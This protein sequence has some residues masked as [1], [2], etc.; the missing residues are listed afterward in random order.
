MSTLTSQRLAELTITTLERT[1][2]VLAEPV[3]EHDAGQLPPRTFYAG[4]NYHGPSSGTVIL[5]ASDGFLCELAAS[6]LGTEPDEVDLNQHGVDAVKELSNIVGGS[7][8]LELGGAQCS[9]SLGLP[10]VLDPAEAAA[11]AERGE[12][13]DI[14]SEGEHLRVTWLPEDVLSSKA[15]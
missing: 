7:V 4:I 9:F 12:H 10:Q 3:D 6:L 8:I 14:E 1:A 13:C 11:L 2:F 15:A 5:S